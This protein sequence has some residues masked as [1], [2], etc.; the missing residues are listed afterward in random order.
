MAACFGCERRRSG[1]IVEAL[2]EGY[3]L[4]GAALDELVAGFGASEIEC[5]AKPSMRAA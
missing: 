5:L 1:A 2:R 3:A 4:T